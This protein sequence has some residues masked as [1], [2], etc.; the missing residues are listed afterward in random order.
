MFNALGEIFAH[1]FYDHL[2][3]HQRLDQQEEGEPGWQHNERAAE[4]TGFKE[5][6]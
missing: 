3:M 2:E 1:G 5:G 4:E 6:N